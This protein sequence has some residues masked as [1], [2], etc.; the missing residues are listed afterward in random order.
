MAVLAEADV[1]GRRA[2]H[3]RARPRAAAGRRVL[4][5]PRAGQLRRPPPARRGPLRGR[6]DA[7]PWAGPPATTCSS[8]TGARTACTCRSTRSRR[9][10]P[11]SGGESPTLSKMGGADWQRTRARARA[12]AD[13][14]AAGAGRA[15]PAPA[16]ASPGHAFGPDTPWQAEMEASFAFVETAD[17][18]RGDRRR[19]GATWRRR[20][21]WTAWSAATSA[22]ARPRSPCGPCSRRSRTARRRRCSCR[23]RCSPASTPRP[24]P[25]A[26]RRYP[27]R[28]ELLSR[29]LSPAAAARRSSQ[30]LADGIGRRGHRHP[31]AA[32]RGRRVQGP[33]ASWSSTR[34]SASA[35]PTRRRSSAWPT[36]VDVLT[37]TASPIP[38]TLEMALTG[39][40]DLSMVNTPPAD[41]R[42]ILTYVGEHDERGRQRGA[43][44][45]AAA[46]GPGLLRA[47]PGRRHRRGGPRASGELVPEARVAVA[48]GQMD[49][50]TPRDGGARLLGAA[51]RRA[52]LH[53]HHRVGHRHADGQH[54]GRRPGRPARA[55]PAPPAPGPGG[56]RR[57]AGL[58]LP[59]PPGRPGALRA[60]LRA[61]AHHRRAHRARLGL[62]DRH[63]R[64]RDPRRGQPARARTS[65]ATS[66][67]SA[68]T[69]TSSW[70]PRRSPRPRARP[71][72]SP[73][74]VSHRRPRR[75][76]PAGD[77]V[78]AEDA[79]LEAYRRLA[80]ATTL[81]RG[82][83]HR[84]RVGGPLRPAARAGR[85]RCS[86]WPACAPAAWRA[87]SREIAMSSVRPGGAPPPVV[88]GRA[89]RAPGQR[90]G[91]PAPPG[92]GCAP[93]RRRRPSCWSRARRAATPPTPCARCSRSSCRWPMREPPG[94][95]CS[96]RGA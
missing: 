95:P 63:A 16:G 79:R 18:L 5:R 19:Q 30:G 40:R 90:P 50:G 70:S 3:R 45:R 54:A 49:E 8:S 65:R 9:I 41:R 22:S 72:P 94:A 80:A 55:R 28:V 35:S 29:F 74:T 58:R 89:G 15:L 61:A 78:A 10:T 38:R 44:P 17:Q 52:G 77:Y 1:T 36:G 68:T 32:G 57:P 31:P 91:A 59:V 73:P 76:P 11:Y 87:G 66:P 27:V 26:T 13:E 60:G 48:H 67:R 43:P 96:M 84:R 39:I 20:G 23:P 71:G 12:A 86:T 37:L 85:G 34:S 53:D 24:S 93:T 69:C 64:P 25:T 88:A 33:R 14:I 92:A 4:R 6:D 46:R 75:R 47:Q 82:R 83:R 51:L 21:R 42:P 56:P 62:Q 81:E 2:P 7:R